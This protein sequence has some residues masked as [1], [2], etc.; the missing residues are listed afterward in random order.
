MLCTVIR[1]SDDW[2]NRNLIDFC[3]SFAPFFLQPQ[4]DPLFC[5]RFY[6]YPTWDIP[7][8]AKA[9]QNVG[10]GAFGKESSDRSCL[11]WCVCLLFFPLCKIL[12]LSISLTKQEDPQM[13]RSSARSL[14]LFKTKTMHSF[15]RTP[16]PLVAEL[17]RHYGH[18]P[19]LCVLPESKYRE[20]CARAVSN[21]ALHRS[22]M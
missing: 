13:R 8:A 10:K 14:N 22:L 9:L 19:Q 11:V 5:S 7:G 6:L 15:V 12:L 3:L 21:D 16:P 18:V 1:I 17:S 2:T 4:A 20:R